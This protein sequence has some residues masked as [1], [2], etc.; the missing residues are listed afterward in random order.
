M[1]RAPALFLIFL[2][3]AGMIPSPTC[4]SSCSWKGPFLTVAKDAPLVVRARVLRHHPG[5]A[6]AMDVLV[7]ET[8]KGGLLD[9]GM[10]IQMGMGCTTG[11]RST[12]IRRVANGFS[13]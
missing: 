12:F 13:R 3:Y 9:T 5:Q 1:K 8:L 2:L 7:L 11:P 4:A 10:V 6:P